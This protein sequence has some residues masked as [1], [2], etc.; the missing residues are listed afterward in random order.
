MYLHGGDNGFECGSPCRIAIRFDDGAAE[1]WV[2]EIPSG[3]EN[4]IFVEEDEKFARI[5]GVKKIAFDVKRE[6]MGRHAVFETGGYDAAKWP[7]L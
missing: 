5:R 1:N 7:A 2:G 4:A 3:G 6:G